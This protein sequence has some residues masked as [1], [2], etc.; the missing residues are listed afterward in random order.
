MSTEQSYVGRGK[1]ATPPPQTAKNGPNPLAVLDGRQSVEEW[2]VL[3]KAGFPY[4]VSSLGRV[5]IAGTGLI[6]KPE[7]NREAN[8]P[9]FFFI[10]TEAG[11][12][13]SKAPRARVI[14]HLAVAAAFI[15]NPTNS[16]KVRAKNGNLLN[17]IASN[18]EWVPEISPRK[19]PSD[20]RTVQANSQAQA[21]VQTLPFVEILLNRLLGE[22]KIS[23]SERNTAE[24]IKVL[25]NSMSPTVSLN[26]KLLT[27]PTNPVDYPSL[28]GKVVAVVVKAQRFAYYLGRVVS[29]DE[30]V[31]R[32]SRDNSEWSERIESRSVIASIARVVS[33][34][35][36]VVN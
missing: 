24:T 19:R 13:Q 5:R 30:D 33:V 8:E 23:S 34:L 36:T 12:S 35:E 14:L 28:V 7:I 31:V 20:I 26:A 21:K 22:D 27:V 2:K 16:R 15:P 4:Q 17:V 1:N 3:E 18:L 32:V 6:V 11:R 25:D 9:Y 29:I 10:A